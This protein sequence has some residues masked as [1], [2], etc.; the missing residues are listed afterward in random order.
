MKLPPENEKICPPSF[1]E[2]KFT[3][4]IFNNEVC[5]FSFSAFSTF[6]IS[7]NLIR[8]LFDLSW[9][10]NDISLFGLIVII[11]SVFLKIQGRLISFLLALFAKY[12]MIIF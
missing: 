1:I 11:P 5:F 7:S 8:M 3:G 9:D 6:T 12:D 10:S 2:V 4:T